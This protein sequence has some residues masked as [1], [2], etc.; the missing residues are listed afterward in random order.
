MWN[1]EP[2]QSCNPVQ[3][4]TPPLLLLP[5]LHSLQALRFLC[6]CYAAPSHC[7]PSWIPTARRYTHIQIAHCFLSFLCTNITILPCHPGSAGAQRHSSAALRC[8]QSQG[9]TGKF[10][11]L[12]V[13]EPK[14]LKKTI[15]CTEATFLALKLLQVTVFLFQ[16]NSQ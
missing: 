10:N 8:L 7:W 2:S 4:Y 9:A 15:L 6:P 14:W 3:C 16:L 11:G 13:T 1:T 5:S 12:E